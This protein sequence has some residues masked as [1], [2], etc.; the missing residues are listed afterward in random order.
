MG[1]VSVLMTGISETGVIVKFAETVFSGIIGAPIILILVVV[2]MVICIIRAF[3]PT[4]TAVIALMAPMLIGIAGITQLDFAPMMMIA[5]FWAATALLLVH[6]E[7]IYLITYK[8]DIF[9]NGKWLYSD[10]Y[11]TK[12]ESL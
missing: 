6:T 12:I 8:D 9:E 11:E 4:T 7:P 1:S 3:I 2:S 5:A 10:E